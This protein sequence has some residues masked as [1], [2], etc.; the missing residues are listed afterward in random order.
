MV[1]D[2]LALESAW[3]L[4]YGGTVVAFLLTVEVGFRVG[5]RRAARAHP[6]EKAQTGTVLAALLGLL[7]FLLAITFGIAESRFT[8]RK[9]LVLGEANAIGTTWLRAGFLG[10]PHG[11]AAR[12]LLREYV[13][14]RLE[15]SRPGRFEAALART[16]AIH[17]ALWTHAEA[18]AAEAP[19]SVPLG[20]FVQSLNDV[21]DLHEE[22]LTV[23]LRYRIPPVMMTTLYVLAFLS[24]GTLGYGAGLSGPRNLVVTTVLVA[25]FSAVLLL[26][27]DL[28]RPQQRLFHV[29]QEALEDT[30]E[31]MDG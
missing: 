28:D 19:R 5:R 18:V 10:A 11:P 12:A 24:M 21:I 23:A 27:V 25:S 1:D 8:E 29:N 2:L 31:S 7:G 3:P 13:D 22:R 9:H 20:L 30:R 16:E 17:R 14:V 6:E 26:I 4:F 15:A